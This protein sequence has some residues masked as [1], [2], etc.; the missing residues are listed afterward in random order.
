MNN[1][2]HFSLLIIEKMKNVLSIESLC[3]HG[4]HFPAKSGLQ[5]HLEHC[6]TKI[7]KVLKD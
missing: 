3:F 6:P 2:I 1:R 5:D 4:N 7:D